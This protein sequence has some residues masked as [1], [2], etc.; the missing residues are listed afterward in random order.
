M[1][2][3]PEVYR[4]P[5]ETQLQ[6]TLTRHRD[7]KV[8][9]PP[10][11]D[12]QSQLTDEGSYLLVNGDNYGAGYCLSFS[13]GKTALGDSSYWGDYTVRITGLYTLDGQHAPLEYTVRFFDAENLS[14]PSDWAAEEVL[15][16]ARLSLIPEDLTD[17]Y[18]QPIT[19]MEFCRLTMQAIRERTGLT[20]EE[21]VERYRLPGMLTTF[22]DCTDPDVLAA[23]AIG[24]V[25]GPGDGTFHPG[26]RITR[27]DAAVMLLQAAAALDLP[28]TEGDGLLY[29]D[30]DAIA[31]YARSAVGWVSG[32]RDGVSAKPVM[33][34]VGEGCFDPMSVYTR[35][36]AMLTILRLFRWQP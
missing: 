2:L 16:A 32:V 36:Q 13:V 19:R 4:L 7:G 26:D 21:L 24:M 31:P 12:G 8:F 27:Q 34:G 35:E 6:V 14:Q 10:V 11:L 33:G 9:L 15:E 18:Q 25:F 30:I 20:N 23:A 17:F 28:L 29:R 22:S 3:D 5:R 1:I